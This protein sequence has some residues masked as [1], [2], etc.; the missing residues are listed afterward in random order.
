MA[1]IESPQESPQAHCDFAIRHADITPP[2]G[3]YHRMWGAAT[4]DRS[5]GIHRPLRATVV[6][7][8]SV[9]SAAGNRQIIVALDHCLL[10]AEEM[11]RFRAAVAARASVPEQQLVVIFSHTHAAGL[12]SLDRVDLP[13][14]GEIPAYLDQMADVTGRLLADAQA[15][16]R[17]VTIVFGSGACDLARH[18]D[19]W[20][21]TRSEYVCGFNPSGSQDR[22]VVVGRVTDSAGKIV[23]TLVNYACHPT[24]LAW[25]NRQISPDFPGAMREI[26]ERETEAP[27]LFIQGASGDL[28]PR[29]GFVGD[30]AVADRNGRQLG[31]A[32]L[33]A[34]EGLDPPNT[35]FTYG[36]AVV[37]GATIGTWKHEPVPDSKRQQLATFRCLRRTLILSYRPGLPNL[38]EVDRERDKWLHDESNAHQQGD[39]ARA[40]DCR[41][42]VERQTRMRARLSQ[43]P[44]GDNFPFELMAWRLGD[45]LWLFVP[46]EHYQ[47]LQRQL[48]AQSGRPIFVATLANGWGPSYLPSENMYGTGAYPETIAILAPGSLEK[49]IDEAGRMLG[50]LERS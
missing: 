45:S 46:G 50:E 43:L 16:V 39:L 10:G 6:V 24:T 13:G 19:L 21:A 8:G 7:A 31:F 26:V 28:G 25:D 17:P 1:I 41:A 35:Q 2:V 33:A 32:A 9:G 36:G 18:R 37:S 22:T 29:D 12:M 15:D 20:D 11:H 42:Q 47:I 14:G 5:E 3:T 30:T 49:V 40:R 48:R 38:E 4:H 44:A 27:C 34:L 23:A